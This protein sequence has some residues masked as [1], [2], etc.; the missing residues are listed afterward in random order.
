MDDKKLSVSSISGYMSAITSVR[1][2][3]TMSNLLDHPVIRDLLRAIKLQQAQKPNKSKLPAW[4]L[5]FVLRALT[6]APFEPVNNYS[7][8]YLTWKTSFLMLLVSGR[9]R[10]EL[11]SVDITQ[12]SWIPRMSPRASS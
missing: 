6:K 5:T 10:G 8:I 3:N 2:L 9:R 1:R 12:I 7:L 11:M 4:N